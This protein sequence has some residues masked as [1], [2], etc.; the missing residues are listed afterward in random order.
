MR[1]PPLTPAI[2]IHAPGYSLTELAI[3]LAVIGLV[4]GAT[5]S[6]GKVQMDIAAFQ[7]TQARLETIRGALLLFQKKYERYPCPALPGDTPASAT[8]GRELA[9][10]CAAA[11]PLGLTCGGSAVIGA[12]PFKNLK[13]GE[14]IAYD[15][16]DGKITYAVDKNHTQVSI[17]NT[18]GI[19]IT[20]ING[21]EIT[22][23]PT[24]GDA[25]FVLASHGQDGKGAYGGSGVPITACGAVGK[26]IE[27]CNGDDTFT[28]SRFMLSDNPAS[29]YDDLIAWQT[30]Q[31]V[32][33][34]KDSTGDFSLKAA[35]LLTCA[36]KN[37]GSIWCWGFN[38]FGELSDGTTI[39]RHAPV[40]AS[41]VTAFL[42]GDLSDN[43]GCIL[44]TEGTVWC[45]GSND[46]FSGSSGHGRIGDG[47][48]N[49]SSMP[50]QV[51]GLT[52]IEK[53]DAGEVHSCAIKTGG[54]LWC[55]GWN[56]YGE[57][58]DGT[59]TQRLRSCKKLTSRF[60]V[61]ALSMVRDEV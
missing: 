22:S 31:N 10:G 2:C 15:S 47:T 60:R 20:D 36:G 58:G 14:E 12:V 5:L 46:A 3:V 45:W 32:E 6:V 57:V 59:T 30:Q 34:K 4:S 17:Y 39:E 8:Y 44:K 56:Q 61:G 40:Q 53:V 18:G 49:N 42:D 48:M 25:I 28:D 19:L 50:V 35:G 33:L 13:I 43:G 16:W 37:D 7:G 29:Y 38:N 55:W 1:S 51:T 52:D 24:M 21:S 41:G 11:C 9:G 23:S 26:D 54:T 27:N